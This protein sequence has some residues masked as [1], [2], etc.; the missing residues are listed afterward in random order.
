MRRRQIVLPGEPATCDLLHKSPTTTN[1][2]LT[3]RRNGLGADALRGSAR[4][5]ALLGHGAQLVRPRAVDLGRQPE[6]HP[7]YAARVGGGGVAVVVRVASFR[8][9]GQE[10]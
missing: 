5:G 4:S 2:A 10:R 3:R 7:R 6:P 9:S 8:S 1:S